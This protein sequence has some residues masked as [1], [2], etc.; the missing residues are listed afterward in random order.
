MPDDLSSPTLKADFLSW[1]LRNLCRD[2]R[3]G[4]RTWVNLHLNLYMYEPGKHLCCH[5]R[6]FAAAS[7]SAD[8]ALPER[9]CCWQ[10]HLPQPDGGH[11]KSLWPTLSKFVWHWYEC[12]H[13][14]WTDAWDSVAIHLNLTC[15]DLAFALLGV[16]LHDCPLPFTDDAR[17][18][19]LASLPWRKGG[20]N[21]KIFAQP[22]CMQN[23]DPFTPHPPA[24]P[25]PSYLKGSAT[26]KGK[27]KGKSSKDS[28]HFGPIRPFPSASASASGPYRSLPSLNADPSTSGVTRKSPPTAKPKAS[29]SA[30]PAPVVR[31]QSLPGPAIVH[32]D[33]SRFKMDGP[34]PKGFTRMGWLHP[35]EKW[36]GAIKD[37]ISA[38]ALP[39]V[40]MMEYSRSRPAWHL[41]WTEA[42]DLM[43]WLLAC[44]EHAFYLFATK[45]L[46]SLCITTP[47]RFSGQDRELLFVM[48][49]VCDG[50]LFDELARVQTFKFSDGK[51]LYVAAVID[52]VRSILKLIEG[53]SAR[54]LYLP[55]GTNL[56][57]DASARFGP[58][59]LQVV[60]FLP[61]LLASS[62]LWLDA[63]ACTLSIYLTSLGSQCFLVLV[64]LC[65]LSCVQCSLFLLVHS[66][67]TTYF[68]SLVAGLFAFL[69][70]F[71]GIG[72]FA[73]AFA[74][75]LA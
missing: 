53:S 25:P 12:H 71:A 9:W 1:T 59:P 43:T 46:A 3:E 17:R 36:G 19:L 23:E 48:A 41:R 58:S 13:T 72:S 67:F 74:P 51:S 32:A 54:R 4:A 39:F 31:L 7:I 66:C 73:F 18:A 5:P 24:G 28:S 69:I 35:V 45:V 16:D 61:L 10:C 34:V 60:R 44:E 42:G 57:G 8:T 63:L 29:S 55:Q 40:N 62:W 50:D 75:L 26:S 52:H 27:G 20:H 49:Q 33:G 6:C 30:Q 15:G 56:G 65:P 64:G 21:P 38:Y 2:W 47:S 22:W 11:Y 70:Y 14:E 68:L 37:E